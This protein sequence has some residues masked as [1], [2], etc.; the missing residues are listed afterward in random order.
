MKLLIILV[1]FLIFAQ[2]ALALEIRLGN[3]TIRI[4]KI[5]INTTN[6]PVIKLNN[7]PSSTVDF[8][9]RLGIS[10]VVKETLNKIYLSIREAIVKSIKESLERMP[11]LLDA[12]VRNSTIEL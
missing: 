10:D 3:L 2:A 9:E 5:T 1:V 7:T 6:V 8:F 4:P 11:E 12:M